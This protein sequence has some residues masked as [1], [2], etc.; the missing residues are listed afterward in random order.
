MKCSECESEAKQDY[1][2][3]PLCSRCLLYNLIQRD[4]KTGDETAQRILDLAAS[5][6]RE[7]VRQKDFVSC[8]VEVAETAVKAEKLVISLPEADKIAKKWKIQDPLV[9]EAAV[10]LGYALAG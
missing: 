2:G 1:E 4:A 8:M 10:Q 9:H 7:L 3:R 6:S 5:Y